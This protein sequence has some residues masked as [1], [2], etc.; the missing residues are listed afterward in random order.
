MKDQLFR[1]IARV[2]LARETSTERGNQEGVDNQNKFLKD[3]EKFL[4]SG[5]GIDNGTKIDLENSTSSKIILTFSYHRMNDNGFYVGWFDYQVDIK[6]PRNLTCDYNLMFHGDE[7]L[8][9]L[10]YLHDVFV[11]TLETVVEI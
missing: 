7:V 11:T 1:A 8:N 6:L 9:D 4:P 2:L 10:D 3:L 5:A